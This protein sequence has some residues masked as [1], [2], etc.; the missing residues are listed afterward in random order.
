MPIPRLTWSTEPSM[1]DQIAGALDEAGCCVI[2]QA[3]DV[4]LMQAIHGEL[5]TFDA[6][7]S[8]GASAF[9]GY[10][11][12]RTGAP[13]P[14]SASFRSIAMHPAVMAAGDH[15]L[16]SATSW[17]FSAAEYIQIGPGETAQRLHRDQ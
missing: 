5:A 14:R 10:T 11:T 4:D 16:E 9:E 1:P 17:R 7:G 2:E 3:A 12:R 8:V 15:I 6:V 13:L